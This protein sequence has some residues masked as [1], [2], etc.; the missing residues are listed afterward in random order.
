M[1]GPECVSDPGMQCMTPA[2]GEGLRLHQSR[3]LWMSLLL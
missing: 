2:P 3:Y 1:K